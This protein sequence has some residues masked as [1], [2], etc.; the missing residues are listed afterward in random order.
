MSVKCKEC[1]NDKNCKMSFS[2]MPSL[3]SMFIPNGTGE[4]EAKG[5]ELENQFDKWCLEYGIAGQARLKLEG[6]ITTQKTAL[7]AKLKAGLPLPYEADNDQGVLTEAE[8]VYN[9]A[10]A[11]MN[12]KIDSL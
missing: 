5:M 9:E 12:A 1:V 4:I 6:I 10:I 2:R 7:V 11:E 8:R 3:C